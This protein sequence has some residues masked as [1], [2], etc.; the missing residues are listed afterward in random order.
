MTDDQ[1]AAE[2]DLY[3]TAL[4]IRIDKLEEGLLANTEATER[5]DRNTA[6]LVLILNSWKG[7][8]VVI[9]FLGKLAKPLAAIGAALGAW[10][11]WRSQK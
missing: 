10:F 4:A 9:D 1:L 2:L 5:V 6:E 8:M 7:A 11:A 3:R